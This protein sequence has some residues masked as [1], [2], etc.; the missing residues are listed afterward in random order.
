MSFIN[1]RASLFNYVTMSKNNCSKDLSKLKFGFPRIR[2]SLPEVFWRIGV[3]KF[4]KIHGKTPVLE[5]LLQQSYRLRPA[6]FLR[7]RLW[8]RCFSV[9]F[10]KFLATPF[11]MEYFQWLLLYVDNIEVNL[12]LRENNTFSNFSLCH[13]NLSS[14]AAHD[15]NISTNFSL[16]NNLS[17][18]YST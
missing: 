1:D 8:H 10:A 15:R 17:L 7:R 16:W 12:I 13:W 4:H 2:S 14:M 3:L 6:T 9:N 11:F 5:S 18:F